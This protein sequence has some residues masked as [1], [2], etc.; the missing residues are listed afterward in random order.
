MQRSG[1]SF[2]GILYLI[3][4]IIVAANHGYLSSL[5]SLSNILSALLAILLWPAL[6]VGA[7]LHL[8][9]GV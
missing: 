4:G 3:I 5:N 7:N 6:L 9:L 2:I 8:S 1:P